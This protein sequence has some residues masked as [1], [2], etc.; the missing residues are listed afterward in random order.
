LVLAFLL[1]F[2]L[3][4]VLV[5][6][7]KWLARVTNIYAHPSSDRWHDNGLIPKFGGV[8]MAAAL[9]LATWLAGSFPTLWP[10]VL[11]S[12]LMFAVGLLDDIVSLRPLFKLALQVAVA[13]LLISL[14]PPLRITG[15]IVPDILLGFVWIVGITNAI[16]LLDNVD[17]LAAGVAA[18]AGAFFLL[19]L[20]FDENWSAGPLSIAMAALVGATL[21]FLLFNFHPASIF[22]GDSGSHLLGSFLAGTTLLSVPIISTDLVP[23]A[24]I[25]V[26]LLLIPILD[27]AFVTLMRGLAGRSAFA[28]GRDHISHRLVALGIG[29]RRA[30]LTLY[31]L[32]ILG[33]GAALGLRLLSP[34]VGWG[35]ATAYLALLG[36]VGLYL[37]QIS[38]TRGA[39]GNVPLPTEVTNRHRAYLVLLDIIAM[40]GAYYL[41]FLIRFREPQL[42]KFLPPFTV[43]LPLVVA[44]QIG[45]M[46]LTGEYRRRWR[47]L[48]VTELVQVFRRCLV[49]VAASVIAVLY[50]HSFEGYSRSVF[51]FDAFI[52]PLFLIGVRITLHG[53][54][55]YLSGRQSRGRASVIYGAGSGGALVARELRQNAQLGLTPIGFID[56]DPDKRRLHIDGLPV[57]GT[58]AQLPAL[59]ARKGAAIDAV[60][61]SIRDLPRGHFEE[62]CH[63]CEP[64]GVDV[65]RMRLTID[66]VEFQDRGSTIVRFP[67]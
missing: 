17:G 18:I 47:W 9:V 21:A 59:L 5:P 32:A 3:T 2:G 8:A 65:R 23:V 1:A 27:T 53:L 30:V 19:I 66:H 60:I 31:A 14:L 64:L 15:L 52:A 35:V 50:M 28:G 4:A 37:G 51:V 67:R 61:V 55:E 41:A 46:W 6:A 7:V 49:A 43:S 12:T 40:S 29:E 20:G 13:G 62:L 48:G 58:L 16:N 11:A 10:V 45:T 39:S 33:G 56:D 25:P 54:D 38:A 24:T 22:M 63:V 57:L 44:V 42:S 34:V 26:F 36:V